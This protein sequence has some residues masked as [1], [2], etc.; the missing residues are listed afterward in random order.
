MSLI[1]GVRANS[2]HPGAVITDVWRKIPKIIKVPFLFVAKFF[3][4][5]CDKEKIIV[6]AFI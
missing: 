6:T 2:V 5:V 4:K 3:F 1:T